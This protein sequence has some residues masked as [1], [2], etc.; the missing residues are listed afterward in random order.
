MSSLR[1]LDAS[2]NQINAMPIEYEHLKIQEI[3]LSMNRLR[4]LPTLRNV[5]LKEVLKRNLTSKHF[6]FMLMST[7]GFRH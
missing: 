4:D 5:S 6:D 1:V 2:N 3:N 7:S